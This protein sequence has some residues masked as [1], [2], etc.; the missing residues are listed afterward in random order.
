MVMVSQELNKL[1]QDLD[2]R[3]LPKRNHSLTWEVIYNEKVSAE[4]EKMANGYLFSHDGINLGE[5]VEDPKAQGV[6][7]FE[8]EDWLAW[9]DVFVPELKRMK[10]V[11]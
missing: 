7:V 8:P 10:L 9:E 3:D 6:F 4:L 5:F 1:L 11:I 2:I